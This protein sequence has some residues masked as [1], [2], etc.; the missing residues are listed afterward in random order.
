M[1]RRKKAVKNLYVSILCYSVNIV[2]A[3]GLRTIFI[4]VL[5]VDYLGI[6]GLFT[7]I[8]SF[9]S[10]AEL[11]IGT[12]I[13]YSLYAP[14]ADNDVELV[15]TYMLIY[16]KVYNV[17]G[18][19]VFILGM[20]LLPALP[21]FIAGETSIESLNLI[22]LL[23]IFNSASSYFFSYN[24]SL[25]TADQKIYMV[26]FYSEIF[27]V[28]MMI[29]QAVLLIVTRDYIFY[30]IA[31]IIFTLLTNIFLYYKTLRVYP[32]LKDKSSVSCL[33][34]EKKN[35]LI[36]NVKALFLHK[37]GS[38][39]VVGVDNI[40]ISAFIGL[41]A[42]GIYSN[43]T[44]IIAN[45]SAVITLI[46]GSIRAGIGNYVTKENDKKCYDF[47]MFNDFIW[48]VI[49]LFCAICL[50]NLLNPFIGTIWLN[51]TSYLFDMSIVI[52]IVLDFFIKGMRKNTLLFKEVYG[53]YDQDKF[54]PLF[55]G[56]L[57]LILSVILV[58]RMGIVGVLVATIITNV[59]INFLVEPYMVF[60][61]GLKRDVKSYYVHLILKVFTSLI[62]IM[63]SMCVVSLIES[64]TV[65]AFVLRGVTAIIVF[66]VGVTLFNFKNIYYKKILSTLKNNVK[67]K[68][69][70]RYK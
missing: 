34:D 48:Y 16:K 64:N 38:L 6:N 4:K 20:C 9:L 51:D 21:Y 3:F 30:L 32:F 68:L 41:S 69:F 26:K 43:Y 55:E 25:L 54:K 17:I 45:I 12:A 8:L 40:V 53:I 10:L 19:L 67:G 1:S 31:S 62:I 37:I 36:T 63:V 22:Y 65:L 5:S 66:S 7:N 29:A 50:V 46:E 24:Q 61:Y 59:M 27:K 15:K 42:V 56:G 35:K 23:F 18:C 60:K 28:C 57:N 47:F 11:G 39:L 44:L 49:Y 70:R 13:V 52:V 58:Q 2:M 14:L 33:D